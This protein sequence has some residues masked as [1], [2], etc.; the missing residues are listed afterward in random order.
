MKFCLHHPLI[1]LATFIYVVIALGW[2]ADR[3]FPPD[4]GPP[5]PYDEL[6]REFGLEPP[7]Q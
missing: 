2:A 1:S 3:L 4:P 5:T 6:A 7:H